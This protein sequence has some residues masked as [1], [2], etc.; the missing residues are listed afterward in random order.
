MAIRKRKP[1][2]PARRFQSVSDFSEITKDRPGA[3]ARRPRRA[4]VDATATAARPPVTAAAATSAST[5]SST[6]GATRTASRPRSRRSSTTRTATA[7]SPSSHYADGEKRYILAPARRRGRRRAAVGPGRRDPARQR[8]PAALRPGRLGAAQRRAAPGRRRQARPRRRDER[9]AR[10][11]G[12]AFATLRL[13]STEMRRVPIDCRGDPRR[14]RQRR[15]GAD[16]DRQGRPQPLARRT[17]ADP[18]RRHEPR[19]PPARRWRGEV[20]RR[21]PP[22]LAVGQARGPHPARHKK[23]DSMIVR[24]RR[25]PRRTALGTRTRCRAA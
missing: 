24:R 15:G 18:W 10:R 9:A 4:P 17:P 7:A 23:S 20:L 25:T 16:L 11:Q 21:T 1:T 2:S 6:S 13:P 3:V 12:R 8:P 19:R 14:G 22:G 5:A